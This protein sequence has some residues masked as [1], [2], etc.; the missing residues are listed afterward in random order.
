MLALAL[1]LPDVGPSHRYRRPQGTLCWRLPSLYRNKGMFGRTVAE[2]YTQRMQ[3]I[4]PEIGRYREAP[5]VR[6]SGW[7]QTKTAFICPSG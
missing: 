4:W 6:L 3:E 2:N 1:S 7:R 5:A